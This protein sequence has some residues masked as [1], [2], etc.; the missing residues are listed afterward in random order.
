MEG[1]TKATFIKFKNLR[2]PACAVDVV[3]AFDLF[4]AE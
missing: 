4:I 1:K 3:T 2:E